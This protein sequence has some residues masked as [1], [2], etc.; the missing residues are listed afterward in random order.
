MLLDLRV[1]L[2]ATSLDHAAAAAPAPRCARAPARASS[3]PRALR[4]GR[5]RAGSS[6]TS[7]V[8]KPWSTR[9]RSRARRA[10]RSVPS[11]SRVAIDCRRRCRSR[12]ARALAPCASRSAASVS[13]VSPDCVIATT[14]VVGA[15]DRV[16]VAELASR[17][18]PR[19]G[20]RASCSI[21][22]LPTSAACHDGAAGEQHDALDRRERRSVEVASRRGRC[23]PRPRD[24]APAQRV[25]RPRAAARRSP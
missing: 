5:A 18:R 6:A 19:P 21:R 14:S 2:R 25:A 1:A 22:N 8:V 3:V 24:D 17:S 12:A 7:C 11:A 23:R 13:A 10:C 16:A 15:D 4:R 20:C 9:R